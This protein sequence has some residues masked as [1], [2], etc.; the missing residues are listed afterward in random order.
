MRFILLCLWS[1]LLAVVGSDSGDVL[2]LKGKGTKGINVRMMICSSEKVAFVR[3]KDGTYFVRDLKSCSAADLKLI[4]DWKS[5]QERPP[6]PERG[7]GQSGGFDLMHQQQFYKD[8]RKSWKRRTR[9]VRAA[10]GRSALIAIE[11]GYGEQ[12]IALSQKLS[13][14]IRSLCNSEAIVMSR[15]ERKR[16]KNVDQFLQNDYLV[17]LNAGLKSLDTLSEGESA[18]K[19]LGTHPVD[20]PEMPIFPL[21]GNI[22]NGVPH[23]HQLKNYCGP[24]TAEM[25]VRYRGKNYK[26]REI[27]ALISEESA[28]HK[29]TQSEDMAEAL[30]GLDLPLELI[31]SRDIIGHRLAD[32]RLRKNTP[33]TK[34]ASLVKK[35]CL[36]FIKKNIDA[37]LPIITTVKHGFRGI[38]HFV[39]VIGY[40]QIGDKPIIYVRDPLER[41]GSEPTKF[42]LNDFVKYWL[43]EYNEGQYLLEAMVLNE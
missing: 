40:D 24:A 15:D 26:Q 2:H 27:A 18:K 6:K 22:L 35:Q 7:E 37:G 28:E 31:G 20:W 17:K 12:I 13:N 25:L 30:A 41:R 23:V 16:L 38:G 3:I 34:V 10:K 32:M 5:E 43:Y 33:E 29:G 42:T 21:R 19:K 39:C 9:A 11:Q 4:N 8:Y 14:H 1:S 36:R